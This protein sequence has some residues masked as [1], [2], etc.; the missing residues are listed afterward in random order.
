MVAETLPRLVRRS[1]DAFPDNEAIDGTTYRQLD[2]LVN[3]YVSGLKDAGVQKGDFLILLFGKKSV[4]GA[5]AALAVLRLGGVHVPLDPSSPIERLC[6]QARTLDRTPTLIV[7]GTTSDDAKCAD[8]L[9]RELGISACSSLWLKSTGIDATTDVS[10]PEDLALI[11]FTSGSTGPPKATPYKH[12]QLS[13]SLIACTSALGFSDKEKACNVIPWVWDGGNLDLFGPLLHGGAVVY[14]HEGS[15]EDIT[16]MIRKHGC[17]YLLLPPSLLSAIPMDAISKLRVLVCGG[18]PPRPSQ[19]PQWVAQCPDT[20]ILH[21]YGLTEAGILNTLYDVTS[22]CDSLFIPPIGKPIADTLAM[23]DPENSEIVLSGPRITEGY[24]GID[25]SSDFIP[26]PNILSNEYYA[27]RTG[28]LGRVDENG[29]FHVTGRSDNRLSIF[30]LRI[31]PADTEDAAFGV[32]DIDFAHLFV[33]ELGDG[34][35]PALVLAYHASSMEFTSESLGEEEYQHAAN[36]YEDALRQRAA[37]VLPGYQVCAGANAASNDE[38]AHGVSSLTDFTISN[39][40]HISLWE[41]SPASFLEKRIAKRSHLLQ[42]KLTGWGYW[43]WHR[44]KLIYEH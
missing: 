9:A 27:M 44:S 24:M 6:T 39:P 1:V 12:K 26:P 28:D 43:M 33:Y 11:L 38:T 32:P 29:F 2:T 5:A 22:P 36:R 8:A 14:C 41:R 16:N 21:A 3:R 42:Q 25:S 35:A 40:R 30:S 13:A 4:E 19:F 18:E 7:S 17:T 34:E 31:E 23:V 10:S 37:D 15:P 20:R